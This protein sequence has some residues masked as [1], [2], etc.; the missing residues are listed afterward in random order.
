MDSRGGQVVALREKKYA[1]KKRSRRAVVHH[2]DN[3][4]YDRLVDEYYG[5]SGFLNFG[6]WDEP[7][8]S[9]AEASENLVDKL[10]SFLSNK[11][12]RI[13]DV[14]C[15]TGATT[16]RLLNHYKPGDVAAIN[17]SHKQLLTAHRNMPGGTFCKM[18]A[19]KL[20]FPDQSFHNMICVE[21]AFHFN[22]REA[23][24]REAARVLK[25]GGT[26]ALSDA[27]ISNSL[28]EK[29]HHWNPKNM[30]TDLDEY[31]A[32]CRHAGFADVQIID[33]TDACWKPCFWNVVR[34]A[35]AKFWDG[36]VTLKQ[37]DAFLDRIYR[38][39]TDLEY[40]ILVAATK[41]PKR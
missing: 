2:Y 41:E 22:T 36:K 7:T 15:G 1:D 40:Y 6:Y 18:D 31:A 34:F 26:L 38:L 25:P 27:L 32:I 5:G 12:G 37:K 3:R 13:L 14:A 17:I 10:L 30:V 19:A 28:K 39:A 29:R 16:C 23:F 20:A 9:A 4:M 11:G 8:A 21:A 33:A 35:H 24:F